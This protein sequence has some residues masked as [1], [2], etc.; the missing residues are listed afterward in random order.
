MANQDYLVSESDL[1]N[2]LQQVQREPI[3]TG[4]A[5]Q[6]PPIRDIYQGGVIGGVFGTAV[7]TIESQIPGSLPT[8]RL[9]PTAPSGSAQGNSASGGI[10]RA[11]SQEIVTSAINNITN[12]INEVITL[13]T[14]GTPNQEQD[15]LNLVQG[16]GISLTA[17]TMGD[18]TIASTASAVLFETNSVANS[19]QSV[20][21]LTAGS[22]VTLT[23]GAGGLVT[24]AAASGTGPTLETNSVANSSQAV[25]NLTAGANV[26]LTAGGG[27]LVTIAAASTSAP[28]F[29]A[30]NSATLLSDTGT[31]SS[32]P[33]TVLSITVTFPSSGGPFRVLGTYFMYLYGGT[34]DTALW[35][36]DSGGVI[37]ASSQTN[38]SGSVHSGIGTCD[39]SGTQYA[40]SAIS[41]F[42]LYAVSGGS[43]TIV[44]A[45]PVIGSGSNSYLKIIVVPSN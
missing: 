45:A 4:S 15:K 7:D 22:N 42:T 8:Y 14:N 25:L 33:W 23:A 39:V 37:F 11:V 29:S 34:S 19:S 44:E 10:S 30:V 6:A 43:P 27:G 32:S 35:I 5:G 26:T 31:L 3:V 41:T 12:N 16:T 24:I 40:N 20:L 28:A 1:P 18:V 38:I 13:E 17:D 21:N 36:R 2:D 9:M